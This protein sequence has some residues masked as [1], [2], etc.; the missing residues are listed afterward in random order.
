MQAVGSPTHWQRRPLDATSS[1]CCRNKNLNGMSK[2]LVTAILNFWKLKKLWC[3]TIIVESFQYF[4]IPLNYIHRGEQ[5][6]V[7]S[8][9]VRTHTTQSF[10]KY[11]NTDMQVKSTSQLQITGL[12]VTKS[13]AWSV[14]H[15]YGELQLVNVTRNETWNGGISHSRTVDQRKQRRNSAS[16]LFATKNRNSTS[17]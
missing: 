7:Q 5:F 3:N 16:N 2:Y 17:K 11:L 14:R 10:A 6:L 12:N 1:I 8:R 9:T 4:E 15:T 13:L